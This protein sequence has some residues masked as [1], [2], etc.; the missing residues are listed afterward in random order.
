V[1]YTPRE[2]GFE[3]RKKGKETTEADAK[4]KERIQSLLLGCGNWGWADDIPQHKVYRD[5]LSFEMFVR[6]LVRDSLRYDQACAQIVYSK[7]GKPLCWLPV[8]ASTIRINED[9]SGYVQVLE[10]MRVVAEFAPEEMLFGVRRP[11]TDIEALGYGY[12]EILDLIEIITAFLWG[13]QYNAA[14]FRQGINTKGFLFVRGSMNQQ[15]LNEFKRDLQT[16]ATGVGQA[17][18]VPI[19]NPTGADAQV[20]WVSLGQQQRDMEYR[21]WMNWLMKV[22]CALFLIDPMEIGFHFGAEGQK[23]SVY[24]ASPEARVTL[25][26]DKGLR[27]LLRSI[28]TWINHWIVERINP[29]FELRFTGIGDY[30]EDERARFDQMRAQTYMTI[31]EVRSEHGLPPLPNNMGQVVANP[32][33]TNALQ[34]GMMLGLVKPPAPQGGMGGFGGE[35]GQEEESEVVSQKEG[36]AGIIE[37]EGS[38]EE[39]ENA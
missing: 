9:A 19:M 12:P 15:Q 6:A 38:E 35:E 18:R 36:E 21:E 10:E 26:K 25:S 11:R 37:K 2:T 7:A 8:D 22:T 31:D 28:E 20:Q 30:Q 17:H 27:P 14:Y 3:I 4:E 39:G 13:F 32:S 5:R 16:M 29:D 24:Q 23:G 1:A 34:L 33:L